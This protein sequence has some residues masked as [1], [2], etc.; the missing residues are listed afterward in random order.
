MKWYTH[1]AFG[2]ALS[3]WILVPIQ[4][5]LA[6]DMLPFKLIFGHRGIFHSLFFCI[7]ACIALWFFYDILGGFA[8]FIGFFSHLALDAMTPEGVAFLYPFSSYRIRGFVQ[9]GGIIELLFFFAVIVA[10]G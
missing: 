2:T 7:P 9:T 1:V 6:L 8:F 4:P 5:L 10:G 3:L